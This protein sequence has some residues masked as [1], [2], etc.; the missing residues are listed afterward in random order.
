MNAVN[1][2]DSRAIA[3][4]PNRSDKTPLELFRSDVALWEARFR[5]FMEEKEELAS[6]CS[7]LT[8]LDTSR[9]NGK[10]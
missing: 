9:R 4:S 3:S 5:S 8:G 6:L 10:R 2:P 1:S 7:G